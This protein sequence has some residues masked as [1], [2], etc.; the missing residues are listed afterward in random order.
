MKYLRICADAAGDSYLTEE[1]WRL[2]DGAFTPPSPAGYFVT[3]SLCTS[4]VLM[5]HHPA[6]YQDEWHRAPAHVLGTVLRGLVRVCTS[7]GDTRVLEPGSQFLATDLTGRGHK[8]EEVNAEAY[9]LALVVLEALPNSRR[10]PRDETLLYAGGLFPRPTHRAEGGRI[11]LLPGG[12]D[13]VTRRTEHGQDFREIN[14]KGYVPGL[15]LRDGSLLTE[16]PVILQFISALAPKSAL[17]P[18]A[19][20]R[21]GYRC[22]EWLNYIATEIHKSFSPLFRPT[23]PEA[24]MKSGKDHLSRRLAT[25]EGHLRDHRYLMGLEFSLADAYLFTVCRWLKDQDLSL[26]DWPS[27]LRHSNEV[28]TRASVRRALLSEGLISAI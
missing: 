8:M 11:A 2:H 16:V 20:I 18:N 24:F 12:V 25:V 17:L 7:D 22:L 4:G 15:L 21:Q 26:S 14:P 3:E 19:D 5:M 10:W 27:L 6:D 28:G 23:T 13:Y 9:D 1:E